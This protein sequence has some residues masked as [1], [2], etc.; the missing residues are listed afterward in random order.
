MILQ[1]NINING[2]FEIRAIKA[3][4][5]EDVYEEKN[6]IMDT[7]R[8]NM[9]ELVG[10]YSAGIPITK[11]ILG[12][13][14]HNP[15]TA[16]ILEPITV[17]TYD[18]TPART[19]LYSQE[20]NDFYYT[21]EWNPFSPVGPDLT[22]TSDGE[23]GTI[24]WNLTGGL[25]AYAKGNKKDQSGVE[26]DAENVPCPIEIQILGRSVKYTITIPEIAANG[27]TSESIIAYTEASLMC[28]TDI[29][30]MKTFPGKIKEPVV[31]YI[32]SWSLL[33]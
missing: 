23:G 21:L 8:T 19:D 20:S 13:K 16:N 18:F 30:S 25:K 10:G 29:F 33:F 9:A 4:G 28:G 14:G 2:Y 22:S 11:F 15:D 24:A 7:A 5:S 26:I 31:K 1:D 3:D 12:T 32:I 6:L 27:P 17:G